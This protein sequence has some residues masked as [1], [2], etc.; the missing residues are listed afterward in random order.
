MGVPGFFAWLLKNKKKLGSKKLIKTKLDTNIKYLMLDT[1]CLLH[2]CVN[3]ILEKYKTGILDMINKV[4]PEF[5]Y[6]GIDGVAPIGK[7]LQQRQRRYRYLYDKSIKLNKNSSTLVSEKLNGIVEPI[8]PITSIELTPGTDYME[9]IH[10]NMINFMT[11][12]EKQ[13]IRTIYSSY[14]EEGEGEH[15]ILQYIKKKLKPVDSVIIYGLDTDLL[16]LSL[17]IGT[18]RDLY[19]MREAQVFNG[20]EVDLDEYPEYN[21]VEIKELHRFIENLDIST[22]DFIMLSYMIGNDFLPGML[23][24]DVKKGGLDKIFEAF[25]KVLEKQKI[26]IRINGF[27]TDKLVIKEANELNINHS[28]LIDILKELVWTEKYKQGKL[29]QKKIRKIRF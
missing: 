5:L 3:N 28:L 29:K 23:T 22:P 8:I 17:G 15:K 13:G 18:D 20:K 11:Q 25:H 2:P 1:N 26:P 9:R 16:F 12:I 6:I 19:I 27:I 7:I 10:N 21:Y 14:H 4:K 24:L